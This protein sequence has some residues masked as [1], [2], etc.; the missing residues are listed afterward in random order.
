MNS[1]GFRG[2]LRAPAF[3]HRQVLQA[4]IAEHVV[5]QFEASA[6]GESQTLQSALHF[7]QINVAISS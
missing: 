3:R 1:L 2:C 6:K 7:A 4:V 5:F